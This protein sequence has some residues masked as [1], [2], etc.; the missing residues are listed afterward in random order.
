M[1]KTRRTRRRTRTRRRRTKQEEQEEEEQEQHRIKK[2]FYKKS[3]HGML[4][5]NIGWEANADKM[6]TRN[7]SGCC[8]KW[9][10]Q[11]T[12]PMAASGEWSDTDDYRLIDALYSLDACCM[13]EV[14]WDNLLEHR[15]GDVCRK[16]WNQMVNRIGE[17]VGKSFGEQ[18][19][20]LAKRYC[21]DLLEA[22]EA[23]DEKPVVC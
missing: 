14:D 23:Y 2:G 3:K 9:Y 18:V 19:E 20:I 5:D 15:P 13:E 1:N 7:G 6:I 12:S 22:R 17:S 8:R 11:L 4:K 10:Y 16:R 21:P